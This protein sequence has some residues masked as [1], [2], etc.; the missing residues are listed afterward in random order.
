VRGTHLSPQKPVKRSDR[1]GELIR[2]E[3]SAIFMRGGLRDPRAEGVIVSA[4]RVTDDLGQARVYVRLLGE[5]NEAQKTSLVDALSSAAGMLRRTLAPAIRTKSV[6]TLTFFW[7]DSIDRGLRM[8]A[9]LREIAEERS[10]E[11]ED[12]R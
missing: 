11:E 7:D 8:E 5:A 4:V 6:P 3:L 10:P 1:L 12:E 2:K 9:L